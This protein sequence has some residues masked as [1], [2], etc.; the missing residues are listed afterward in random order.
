MVNSGFFYSSADQSEKLVAAERA[1]VD[2]RVQITDLKC[3]AHSRTSPPKACVTQKSMA[4][5]GFLMP[6]V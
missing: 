3:Q 4:T 6:G 2:A 5:S 1:V